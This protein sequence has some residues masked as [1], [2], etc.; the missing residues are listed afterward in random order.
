MGYLIYIN[1]RIIFLFSMFFFFVVLALPLICALYTFF[2]SY[3]FNIISI[4]YLIVS[5]LYLYAFRLFIHLV[6]IAN[7]EVIFHYSTF[8]FDSMTFCLPTLIPSFALTFI[9]TWIVF[10]T[11]ILYRCSVVSFSLLVIIFTSS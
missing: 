5:P 9:F 8:P 4:S 6:V 10:L 11:C 1:T 7:N 2:F 3:C